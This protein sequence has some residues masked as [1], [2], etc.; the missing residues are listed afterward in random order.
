MFRP[1][2]PYSSAD[3]P[4]FEIPLL[5][6]QI[7]SLTFSRILDCYC[8]NLIFSFFKPSIRLEAVVSIRIR[9][10]FF[11]KRVENRQHY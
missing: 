4:S 2:L 9:Q 8:N 7:F 6:K 5:S 3:L 10:L 1:K 11:S